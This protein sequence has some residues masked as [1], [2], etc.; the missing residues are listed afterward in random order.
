MRPEG[1]QIKRHPVRHDSL[2]ADPELIARVAADLRERGGVYT[3]AANWLALDAAAADD[4]PGSTPMAEIFSRS[5]IERRMGSSDRLLDA[6]IGS[7][8][9]EPALGAPTAQYH[10]FV[11]RHDPLALWDANVADERAVQDLTGADLGS[12]V[13]LNLLY[14]FSPDR[15]VTRVLE[16]GGG[17][18]RMAEAAYN[19]F[20]SSIRWVV[21]DAVPASLVYAYEYLSRACPDARVGAYYNGDDFDLEAFDLYVVPTWRLDHQ[22]GDARYETL[23]NIES[24]QEMTQASVDAYLELFDRVAVDDATV[25][26]A[27]ARDYLFRGDWNYPPSWRRVFCANTP[28]SWTRD[29]PTEIFVRASGDHTAVNAALDAAYYH[30]L[31]PVADAGSRRRAVDAARSAGRWLRQAARGR[32]GG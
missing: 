4:P 25:Y 20:G 5:G 19:V 9:M 17:Y 14:T 8:G 1:R 16:V 15:A 30:G 18:G 22:V 10:A 31:P 23:V 7:G 32:R 27:N 24:M 21:A 26:L 6:W 13:D 12:I 3:P 2:R 29:H 28:R 11:R